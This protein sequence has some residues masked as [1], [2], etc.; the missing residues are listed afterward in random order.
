MRKIEELSRVIES[1]KKN[2]ISEVENRGQMCFLEIT[3]YLSNVTPRVGEWLNQADVSHLRII[4]VPNPD[5]MFKFE[6]RFLG[7]TAHSE[8]FV[9]GPNSDYCNYSYP[10]TKWVWDP[11]KMTI[12]ELMESRNNDHKW[13][14]TGLDLLAKGNIVSGVIKNNLTV[15]LRNILADKYFQAGQLMEASRSLLSFNDHE[16]PELDI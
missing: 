12:E 14:M 11:A 9:D 13:V 10:R 1:M 15:R 4:D 5:I 8:V 7:I 3:E 6:H 16:L 2:R